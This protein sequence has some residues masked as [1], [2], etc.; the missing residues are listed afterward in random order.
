MGGVYTCPNL[1]YVQYVILRILS[2]FGLTRYPM[3]RSK[4]DGRIC[5]RMPKGH[6]VEVRAWW[7]EWMIYTE[8]WIRYRWIRFKGWIR[9][10]GRGR[11][12]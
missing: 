8:I 6:G 9:L 7:P 5:W 2:L 4:T 3:Y 12:S 11:R 10:G 1:M